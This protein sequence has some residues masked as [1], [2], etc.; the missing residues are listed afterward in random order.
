MD[1]GGRSFQGK[2]REA[3]VP[4]GLRTLTAKSP[5]RGSWGGVPPLFPPGAIRAISRLRLS[6]HCF[7]GEWEKK[8]HSL[9]AHGTW[10]YTPLGAASLFLAISCGVRHYCRIGDTM[11]Q[12][13]VHEWHPSE[14]PA[15][16]FAPSIPDETCTIR[17]GLLCL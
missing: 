1:R 14:N 15:Y 2:S 3:A 5:V 4:T 9:S 16:A 11:V 17:N 13:Y 12:I 8:G 6:P 7:S 10:R